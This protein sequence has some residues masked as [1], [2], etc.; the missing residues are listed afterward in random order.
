MCKCP[1]CGNESHTINIKDFP[2]YIRK[3]FICERCGRII[4]VENWDRRY[5]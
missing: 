1:V 4:R 2:L 3:E 5:L